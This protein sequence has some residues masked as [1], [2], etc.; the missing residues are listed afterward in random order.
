MFEQFQ[1]HV[2][3]DSQEFGGAP[4]PEKTGSREKKTKARPLA[5]KDVATSCLRWPQPGGLLS[6]STA[7]SLGAQGGVREQGAKG[8][9]R[10]AEMLAWELSCEPLVPTERRPGQALSWLLLVHECVCVWGQGL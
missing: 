7:G 1:C 8:Q 10:R 2:F 9:G 5:Q 3:E 4:V 6:G